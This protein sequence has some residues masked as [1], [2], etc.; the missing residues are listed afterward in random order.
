M[1]LHIGVVRAEQL[2]R[3]VDGKLLRDVDE[4]A[5]AVVAL[6]GIAFR[7]LV[8]Q[9]RPLR[10]ED[11]AARVVLG[12]DQLDV[13]FLARPLMVERC[14]EFGVEP[15]DSLA[16]GKH[17]DSTVGGAVIVADGRPAPRAGGRSQLATKASTTRVHARARLRR[18]YPPPPIP[19]TRPWPSS[20]AIRQTEAAARAWASS[21][22]AICVIGSPSRLSAQHCSRMNSGRVARRYCW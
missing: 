13:L 11:A 4:F 14:R 5:A 17:C 22:N 6:P 21:V 10:L 1:R 2:L 19:S 18:L 9:H 8:G 16:G 15:G 12:G 20:S 3:A 7:V